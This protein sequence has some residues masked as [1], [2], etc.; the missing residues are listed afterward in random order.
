MNIKVIATSTSCLDY[1]PESIDIDLIRIKIHINDKEYIDGETLKAHE[2]YN[3]L[4]QN[5]KLIPK[6]SQPSVGELIHYFKQLANQGYKEVFITTISQQLSGSFN[7]I[8]QASKIVK[9]K[10]KI[11]P[12]DTNTVCFSEG[13]FALEAQRLLSEGFSV[14]NV[15]KHLDVLKKNNTIFFVVNSLT[16]LINNGR[17]N[18]FQSLLGRFFGVK[19]ILQVNQNG[20]IV[21]INKYLTVDKILNSLITKIQTYTKGRPFTLHILFT[22]NP[23]L[24]EKL[25]KLLEQK[26]QLFNILAIPSTPAIGA[27]V[28]NNVV[29]VGIFLHSQ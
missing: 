20:Q 12:Y 14:E 6:T 26:F 24:K 2:F 23:D 15:I 25:R 27:H 1:Y 13:F 18:K 11:I 22:G 3:L 16:Q 4:N 9:K 17:L 7:A 21:L 8:V 5:P 29:G 19:T 28:G 10:I